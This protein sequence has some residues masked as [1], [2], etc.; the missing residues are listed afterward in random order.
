VSRTAL[1][2][3]AAVAFAAACAPPRP[4]PPPLRVA[5][6]DTIPIP[7][8]EMGTRTYK[9]LEGGLYHDRSNSEPADH[10]SIGIKHRNAVQPLDVNGRP[11]RSGRYVLMS[12]G[13]AG[14]SAAWCSGSSAPPCDSG[15]LAGR[16]ASDTSVNRRALVIVNGAIP[17]ANAAMWASPASANY[18]RIRDTRLAPLGL[19]EKQVQ[20]IWMI[21]ADSDAILP[22]TATAADGALRLRHLGAT[23]RALKT[24]YPNLQLLFLSSQRFGGYRDG[25]EPLAYESGFA[26]RWTVD[27]QIDQGRGH[28]FNADA[29]DLSLS[30]TAPWISWGP[31]IWARGAD[32]RRDGLAWARADYDSAGRRLSAQGQQKLG[33]ILFD[34][35]RS[36]KYTRCWFLAGQVCG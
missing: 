20:V 28:A 12:V 31:Y 3:F 24:R 11:A 4:L 8:V 35:F 14:V 22:V 13:G 18:N 1:F 10:D 6:S 21:L 19:S 29:G 17:A 2:L 33:G 5:G 36:S 16:A 7:L 34:F 23:I 32:P 30:G 27:S 15:S 26:V 25:G 9:G